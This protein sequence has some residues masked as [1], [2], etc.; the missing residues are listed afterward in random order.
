MKAA[1]RRLFSSRPSLQNARPK[2]EEASDASAPLSP[3][4]RR[5]TG[6][7]PHPMSKKWPTQSA[8]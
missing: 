6:V 4:A 2:G 5:E 1:A 3:E 8:G 7:L